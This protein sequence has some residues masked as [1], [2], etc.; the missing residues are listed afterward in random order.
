MTK[1]RRLY[2][3]VFLRFAEEKNTMATGKAIKMHGKQRSFGTVLTNHM[4]VFEILYRKKTEQSSSIDQDSFHYVM[5][6]QNSVEVKQQ[7]KK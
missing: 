6:V 2:C 7:N 5:N 4:K 3:E 1:Q